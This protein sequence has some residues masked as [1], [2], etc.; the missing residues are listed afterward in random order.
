MMCCCVPSIRRL[1]SARGFREM[2]EYL[3]VY[4]TL[5]HALAPA[6]LKPLTERFEV[7]GNATVTGKLYELDDYPGATL[8][9]DGLVVGEVVELPEDGAVLA[10]LDDYE[11]YD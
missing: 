8:E 4:G 3:F 9:Q 2:G 6:K 1:R 5:R 11:G 7:I 10:V